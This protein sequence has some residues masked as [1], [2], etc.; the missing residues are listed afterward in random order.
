MKKGK[1]IANLTVSAVFC[2]VICVTAQITVSSPFALPFTLQTFGVALCGYLLGV[3]RTLYSVGAYILL[4]IIGIPVFAGFGGGIQTLFG[5][6][7]G[8]I[9]GF[10]GLGIFC[11]LA[12][13]TKSRVLKIIYSVSGLILCHIS[14]VI[15]LAVISHTNIFASFLTAS[16]PFILK[17]AVFVLLAFIVAKIIL[18]RTNVFK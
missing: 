18:K 6:S 2:A 7:G 8:F 17:D 5:H 12:N 1:R 9:I 4:G 14:G 10:L 15:W 3:K 13:T 11:A 16:A